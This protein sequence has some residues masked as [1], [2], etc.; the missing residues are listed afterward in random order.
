MKTYFDSTVLVSL[1]NA[2][3]DFHAAAQASVVTAGKEAFTSSHALAEVY[4][5]LTTMKLP[6]PPR[7]AVELLA[8]LGKRMRVV[9]LPLAIYRAALADV[10]RQGLAGAILYDAIHCHAARAGNAAVIVTRNAS[11][12]RFFAGTIE[13]R[14]ISK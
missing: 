14:E 1:L 13:V 12:F 10:A 7:A 6:V 8:D 5:T 11:H 2:N 9:D 4:R 3:S